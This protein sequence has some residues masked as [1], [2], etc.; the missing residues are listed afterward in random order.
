M[1]TP[2]DTAEDIA[3]LF[4]GVDL[5]DPDNLRVVVRAIGS[6]FPDDVMLEF[7]RIMAVPA[8][9]ALADVR[10]QRLDR[11]IAPMQIQPGGAWKTYSPFFPATEVL[12]RDLRPLANGLIMADQRGSAFLGGVLDGMGPDVDHVIADLRPK[13]LDS[14]LVNAVLP[15]VIWAGTAVGIVQGVAGDIKGLWDL[16]RD[17]PGAIESFRELVEG[18]LSDEGDEIARAMGGQIGH[19]WRAKL[20]ELRDANTFRFIYEIGRLVGPTVV[21]VVLALLTDGASLGGEA[22][23]AAGGAAKEILT[24]IRS[25]QR[26][27]KALNEIKVTLVRLYHDE[28]GAINLGKLF[29]SANDNG[30]R[31]SRLGSRSEEVAA[32]FAEA[33]S[34]GYRGRNTP[35]QVDAAK[36]RGIHV[37]TRYVD[38]HEHH[39]LPRAF[40]KWF[41]EPPRNLDVDN[42]VV[43]LAVSDHEAAHVLGWNKYWAAFIESRD[44]R[45]VTVVDVESFLKK[46]RKKYD[47]KGDYFRYTKAPV[48]K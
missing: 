42:F 32:E 46:M 40:K 47:I 9:V 2:N 12:S 44:G 24:A 31:L 41:A 13:L 15:E 11:Q 28:R 29:E 23:K 33:G 20:M 37:T 17:L 38:F 25:S 10:E 27:M 30:R 7:L 48:E 22:A 43:R 34:I 8:G 4:A 26:A 18:L 16:I 6:S 19:E 35:V 39:L 14:A 3:R 21:A 1:K 45:T 5:S 36:R